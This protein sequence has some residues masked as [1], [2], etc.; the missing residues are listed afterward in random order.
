MTVGWWMH[1]FCYTPCRD[2][3][4]G[5]YR[6]PSIFN[7]KVKHGTFVDALEGCCIEEQL[8]AI[9]HNLADEP[10]LGDK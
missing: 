1:P 9:E 8:W 4:C 5:T 10:A 3:D 2:N 7:S 6:V